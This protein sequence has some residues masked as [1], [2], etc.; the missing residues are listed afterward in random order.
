MPLSSYRPI[1]VHR[2]SK[3]LSDSVRNS[4]TQALFRMTSLPREEID[5]RGTGSHLDRANDHPPYAELV[6][7]HAE[8][9]SVEGLRQRHLHLSA[10]RQR[11]EQS[12]GVGFVLGVEREGE[13]VE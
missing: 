7:D 11:I 3:I 6:G 9:L 13:A 10:L 4:R 2:S 1:R 5:S 12:L 8:A